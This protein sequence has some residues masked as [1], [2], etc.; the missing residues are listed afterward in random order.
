MT[1]ITPQS[2]YQQAKASSE[3]AYV[4]Y[5]H[6]QVGCCIRGQNN[7]LFSGCNIEN[8]AYGLTLCAEASAIACM[9]SSGVKDIA[10]VVVMAN[11]DIAV[12]PCG[13]CRQRLVE[14]A[15]PTTLIHLGNKEKIYKTMTLEQLLP[16]SF[17]INH[18]KQ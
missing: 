13:A 6:F 9:V 15:A 12:A 11:S 7:Q 16:E 3:K 8:V 10:E 18:M 1:T 17:S 2:M 14:F 4:P 5:S